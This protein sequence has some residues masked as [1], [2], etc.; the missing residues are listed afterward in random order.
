MKRFWYKFLVCVLSLGML[1]P[2]WISSAVKASASPEDTT[3]PQ[4]LNE[5]FRVS[6]NGGGYQEMGTTTSGYYALGVDGIHASGYKIDFTVTTVASEI[7]KND[8]FPLY[9][10]PSLADVASL[11]TYYSSYPEPWKSYL[12]GAA[13]GTNP[14]AY[15]KG[16][17][18]DTT[19]KLIDGAKFN[20]P[21]PGV[22]EEEMTVPGDYVPGVYSLNGSILDTNN[23]PALVNYT[24]VIDA[25]AP[26][27]NV[28][29]PA[30]ADNVSGGQQYDIQWSATDN[31]SGIKTNS[32]KI[33]FF[34]GSNWST[35]AQNLPNTG[36]YSWNV[37]TLNDSDYKIRV[38]AENNAWITNKD[39]TGK[40]TIGD[41][42]PPVITLSGDQEV[43]VL[44]GSNYID[45]GATA[46]DNYDGDVTAGIDTTSNVD[47]S[48]VD[49]YKVTYDVDD[50]AGNHAVQ[51]ERIVKVVDLS[52]A[53]G[54]AAVSGDGEVSLSWNPVVGAVS[55]NVYYK[56]TSEVDY[57]GPVNVTS[58][59]TKITGLENGLSYDFK[60][61]AVNENGVGG[62]SVVV[63]ATPKSSAVVLAS[64]PSVQD[65]VVAQPETPVVT[66]EVTPP[67][68]ETGPE[69]GQIKGEETAATEEEDINWTPWII[70]FVLIVLAGAATGG[71]FYW[72]GNEEEEIVSE[73]VI[74][75]TR[76]SNGKKGSGSKPSAKKSKRW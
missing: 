43:T 59:S 65:A 32:V 64:A 53:E 10:N 13:N 46:T 14:F 41:F 2:T 15:I 75:K 60:V 1:Y 42:S 9:L 8:H 68:E 5:G 74:E 27:V 52:A 26:V 58:T 66:P 69:I 38:V 18:V 24:L 35:L 36:S 63:T 70:L 44:K 6:Q 7:L 11:V 16:N 17:G 22:V 61:V 51:V 23:N 48:I 57:S 73:K 4:I 29:S 47:T 34:D 28:L 49:E 56:K 12:T 55:Y 25:T 30:S 72:F 45:S 19:V 62:E 39:T 71:Y 20:V 31:E 37:G 40:F 76:K 54:L 67:T 50:A 33:R 3:P 21:V